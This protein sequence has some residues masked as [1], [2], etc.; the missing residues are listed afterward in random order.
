MKSYNVR[1]IA[2][3][4]V[5]LAFRDD[6]QI[7]G[8]MV[9]LASFAKHFGPFPLSIGAALYNERDQRDA[10]DGG[11]RRMEHENF[12]ALVAPHTAAMARVPAALVGIADAE[13]AAQEAL[14]R[15]WR[16]WPS[17]R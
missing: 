5:P 4:R 10:R 14:L 15:A 11:A 9:F 1:M 12:A 3:S 16:G 6:N 13:D 17:L 8:R 7:V 2:T